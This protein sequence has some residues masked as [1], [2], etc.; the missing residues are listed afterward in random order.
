MLFLHKATFWYCIE[1]RD[2]CGISVVFGIRINGKSES[3]KQHY[4]ERCFWLSAGRPGHD[5]GSV[6]SSIRRFFNLH[7][8][9]VQSWCFQRVTWVLPEGFVYCGVIKAR[10]GGGQRTLKNVFR[11]Q[12]WWVNSPVKIHSLWGA[13]SNPGKVQNIM[14]WQKHLT[15]SPSVIGI[16]IC[17]WWLRNSQY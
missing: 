2:Y 16:L 4:S 3:G 13:R 14:T 17:G 1:I 9:T 12:D 7:S 6:R 8:W 15:R 5:P 10:G 11:V